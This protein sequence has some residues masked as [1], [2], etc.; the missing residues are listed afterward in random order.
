M[1]F[2]TLLE[3]FQ[4]LDISLVGDVCLYDKVPNILS[5]GILNKLNSS[6]LSICNF[7]STLTH[8]MQN[9]LPTKTIHLNR[10]SEFLENFPIKCVNLS[11]NHILDFGHQGLV[12]TTRNLSKNNIDYFG[13]SNKRSVE[14]NIN[15]FKILILGYCSS[16]FNSSWSTEYDAFDITPTKFEKNEFLNDVK[17]SKEYDLVIINMHW[18]KEYEIENHP[19]QT[20]L[21]EYIIDNI[22]SKNVIIQGHHPHVQQE[23]ETYKHGLI[24][25]SLGNFIFNKIQK[26]CA[27][28]NGKIVKININ[29]K[30]ELTYKELST[31]HYEDDTIKLLPDGENTE[32]HFAYGSNLDEERLFTRIDTRKYDVIGDAVLEDYKF[33]INSDNRATI[34]PSKGDFVEG[35]VL[36]ISKAAK[37]KLDEFE[38]I[39][40]NTYT[41]ET[42]SCKINN[43][44]YSCFTYMAPNTELGK[45]F[46]YYYNLIINGRKFSDE[47]YKKYLKQYNNNFALYDI[48]KLKEKNTKKDTILFRLENLTQNIHNNIKYTKKINDIFVKIYDDLD[49]NILENL[50]MFL[51]QINKQLKYEF[52]YLIKDLIKFI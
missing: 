51:M 14:Y 36:K 39:V 11:N 40:R 10:S 25:Y 2:N 24:C 22:K 7:E 15:N 5:K 13:L 48:S 17:N 23:V 16:M 46:K 47:Y 26:R 34:I 20:Y 4:N 8:N 50:K 44:T 41:H 18:G 37:L 38:G 45:P 52:D 35:R 33:I 3:S 21:A 28:E 1:N 12:D 19:K 30:H 6:D 29:S 32:L 9:Q 31:F 42:V 27:C 49:N 43:K